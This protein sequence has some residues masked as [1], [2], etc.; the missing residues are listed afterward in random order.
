MNPV[1]TALE[2][3][4][5]VHDAASIEPY[6]PGR[7]FTPLDGARG[8]AVLM[9]IAIHSDILTGLKS[10]LRLDKFVGAILRQ[11]GAGVGLFFVLSGFLITGILLDS[12]GSAGYF[13]IFYLRRTLRIF[14]LYY[15]FLLVYTV[16]LPWLG[17]FQWPQPVGLTHQTASL[18]LYVSN[19]WCAVYN[20]NLTIPAVYHFWTLAVEEQF[21]LVWP[22]LV[23]FA[24]RRRVLP[25]S[26]FLIVAAPLCRAICSLYMGGHSLLDSLTFCQMDSLACGACL[27]ATMRQPMLRE[28]V[29]RW[30]RYGLISGLIASLAGVVVFSVLIPNRSQYQFQLHDPFKIVSSVGG[31]LFASLLAL[32]LA[33][34]KSGLV[35]FFNQ[36]WLRNVGKYSYSMY[37]LHAPLIYWLVEPQVMRL[38]LWRPHGSL[39]LTQIV[40]YVFSCAAS[41]VAAVATW[42]LW[43]KWFLRLKDNFQYRSV[44]T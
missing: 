20:T 21:Y 2:A 40:L 23:F 4:P 6:I 31:I 41:Y 34:G 15:G 14:P 9:V 28:R 39:L 44:R 37:L 12:L 10:G 35:R 27:A 13:K 36:R 29:I 16:L 8:L 24:G 3:S 38:P 22:L 25:T 11:G 32:L 26:L 30:A 42:N 19:V 18:W 33:G 5:A 1:A 43:E 7:H 17:G